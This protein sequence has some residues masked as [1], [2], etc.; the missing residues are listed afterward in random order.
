MSFN[1]QCPVTGY[2]DTDV[3]TMAHGSGGESMQRLIKEMFAKAFPD[4]QSDNDAAVVNG[5]G[6]KNL[7]ISTD[8]FV[9]NPIFFP[10][11]DIGSLSVHGT[12]NDISMMGG[13]P[14][15]MTVSFIL[16]EGFP[17]KDLERVVHSIAEASKKADVQIVTGDTK[18]V[19]RGE[20]NGIYINTTGIGFLFPYR[21]PKPENV[22]VGNKIIVSGDIGRHGMAIMSVRNGLELDPPILSDSAPL[23]KVV[24]KLLYSVL[25]LCM[26]DATRGGVGAVLNEIARSAKLHLRID[27]EKIPV[28]EN[29]RGLAEILGLDP[30]NI[31]NEG[32][33]VLFVKPEDA[34]KTVEIL[35]QFEG[36]EQATIIGEVVGEHE[37]GLVTAKTLLG[38]EKIIHMPAG[39]LLPRIC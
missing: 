6:I 2:K 32:R 20:G 15:W 17:M 24:Q 31:A 21:I 35:R 37:R 25:P 8:S 5:F 23:N 4:L 13:I 12:V 33:F 18:V 30:L 1:L 3:V 38:S 28:D 22:E 26:R 16:E 11:G 36:G 39:E 34:E 27:E 10:G 7:V 29:V 19:G 14:E 9:V